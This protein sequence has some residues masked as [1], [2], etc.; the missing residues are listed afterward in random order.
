MGVVYLAENTLMGRLEVLK[1]VGGHVINRRGVLERFLGEIR[2][3]ARL[4]HTN[5]VTAY[6]VVRLGESLVLAMEYVEGLDLAR[7]VKNRGPLPVP[8]PATTFTRRHSACSTPHEH[9]MVHRDIKPANL[10]L[11]RAGNKPVIKVLDFG[12]AKVASEGQDDSGLT[13]RGRCSARRDFIAPEQIRDAR[14][15]DIRADIYSLGC[16][17]YYLLTGRPPFRGDSLW[18]L[19]QAHFSM[20]AMP[21]NLVR[22][23]VPAELA[24]LVAKMMAK[25]PELRFQE[26][27]E[28]AQALLPF[29]KPAMVQPAATGGEASRS[30]SRV[31]PIPAAQ[32]RPPAHRAPSF[33]SPPLPPEIRRSATELMGWRGKA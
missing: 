24:A 28:V 21:L 17:F 29:F 5:V 9:G 20:D 27:K 31:E 30:E 32:T 6:A 26:P 1:V 10:M 22:P 4:H 15:A 16:T 3:A 8:T 11:A 19:Y 18:D 25:E 12:L 23:E 13:P 33:G 14:S 7:L 2:N